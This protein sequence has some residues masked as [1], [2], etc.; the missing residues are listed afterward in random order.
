MHKIFKN[1]YNTIIIF[2]SLFFINISTAVSDEILIGLN[3]TAKHYCVCF[4]ISDMES[5]YCDE[6]YDRVISASISNDQLFE[7]INFTGYEKDEKKKEIS[8]EYKEYKV[9]S[10]FTQET[11]CYFKK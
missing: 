8:I 6:A 5:D 3:A 1:T 11:G 2:S 9:I 4:F 10:V 7:E